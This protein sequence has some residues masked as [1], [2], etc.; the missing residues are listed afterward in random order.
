MSSKKYY[1]I[2]HTITQFLNYKRTNMAAEHENQKP[3]RQNV[4]TVF[5]SLEILKYIKNT[6]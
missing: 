4:D 5:Y 6:N 2:T 1:S 3:T